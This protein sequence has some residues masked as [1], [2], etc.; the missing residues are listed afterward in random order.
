[1]T[2]DD[3]LTNIYIAMGIEKDVRGSFQEQ[4]ELLCGLEDMIEDDVLT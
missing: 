1:M 3:V 4:F 2:Q